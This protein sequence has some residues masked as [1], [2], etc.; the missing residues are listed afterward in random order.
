MWFHCLLEFAVWG[1][2][3][4]VDRKMLGDLHCTRQL[5]FLYSIRLDCQVGKKIVCMFSLADL[6]LEGNDSATSSRSSSQTVKKNIQLKLSKPAASRG[7]PKGRKGRGKKA[8]T[9]V[10]DEAGSPPP[11]PPVET[12][13]HIFQLLRTGSL[14]VSFQVLTTILNSFTATPNNILLG[15][16]NHVF[17]KQ[18]SVHLQFPTTWRHREHYN[19]RKQHKRYHGNGAENRGI[20][21]TSHS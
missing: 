14:S 12:G 10:K 1:G 13:Q 20:F 7:R 5:I 2:G 11:P 15:V 18:T 3:G 17:T 4:G 8:I 19:I 21:L 6:D 16:N 9:P